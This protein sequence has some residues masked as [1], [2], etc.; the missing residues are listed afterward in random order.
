M[1]P[2][3]FQTIEQNLKINKLVPTNVNSNRKTAHGRV[4]HRPVIKRKLCPN[5]APR[6]LISYQYC[7]IQ[8]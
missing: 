4:T 5:Q 6:L 8:I 1:S 3:S 7:A 2:I